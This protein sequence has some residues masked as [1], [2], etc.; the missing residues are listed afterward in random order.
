[1]NEFKTYHPIVNF[2]Y[3]VL[4]IGFAMFFM[5]PISLAISLLCSFTYS[6]VL[7][8]K[9]KLKSNLMYMLPMMIIMALINPA[10]NHEGI[11]VLAYLPSGNPLTLESILYGFAAAVMIVSVICYFSCYNEVM[12]SDKFIYLFGRIIPAMSLILSM[13]LR[14]VPRFIAQLKVVANA[15][16]GMGRD[17]SCGSIIKRAKHGL[18]ILS[19]MVTWALENAIETADSMKARGYGIG[20]RTAFSIFTFDKRDMKCLMCIA[21]L[22][23]YTFVGNLTGE[24]SFTYFPSMKGAEISVFGIS[25]FF[26]YFALCMCP[27]IIELWEVRKWKALKSKI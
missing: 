18:N 22:G 8:G 16:R 26:S 17:V 5:H 6:A 19:I 27:V 4:V 13:T 1:M 3:F 14:F 10:F 25:T 12:T 15:Q 7:G 9:K 20:K 21:F 2:I 24:M 11:S 23:I